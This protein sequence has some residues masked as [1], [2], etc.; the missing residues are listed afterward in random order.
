M[1][2]VKPGISSSRCPVPTAADHSKRDVAQMYC[3][4]LK[5]HLWGH[6]AR[7]EW[8]ETEREV[9]RQRKKYF[10]PKAKETK[11]AAITDAELKFV[12]YLSKYT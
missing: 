10:F 1:L 5:G 11:A 12:Q 9:G 7:M 3:Q 6:T 2:V 8:G 4:R